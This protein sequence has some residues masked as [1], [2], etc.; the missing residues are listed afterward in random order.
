MKKSD[1][2][3]R[4]KANLLYDTCASIREM[5][6]KI[7]S[8]YNSPVI[9][10]DEMEKMG[11]CERVGTWINVEGKEGYWGLFT[12]VQCNAGNKDIYFRAEGGGNVREEEMYAYS[13]DELIYLHDE[14]E[15]IYKFVVK[16]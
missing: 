2:L 4:H 6:Y 5:V 10:F 15:K 11:V 3:F 9:D 13:L 1:T 12:R 8:T 16:K 7:T 14:L